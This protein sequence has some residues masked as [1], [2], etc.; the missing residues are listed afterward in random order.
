VLLC[1]SPAAA[2][3]DMTGRWRVVRED[4]DRRRAPARLAGIGRTVA[5]AG[6]RGGARP[7]AR[8]DRR[9]RRDVYTAGECGLDR[10]GRTITC[11]TLDR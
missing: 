1:V 10:S 2:Q 9:V 8:H 5:A 11:R 7:A 4:R 6:A 3:I